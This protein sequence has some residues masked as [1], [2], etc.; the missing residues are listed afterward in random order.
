MY[1]NSNCFIVN[2]CYGRCNFIRREVFEI[3]LNL[4]KVVSND[5]FY[6][7]VGFSFFDDG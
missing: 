6:L 7:Y 1:D 3:K 2:G 4:S 5:I